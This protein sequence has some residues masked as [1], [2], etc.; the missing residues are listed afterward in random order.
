MPDSVLNACQMGNDGRDQ[1]LCIYGNTLLAPLTSLPAS[2]QRYHLTLDSSAT[3]NR[4][5]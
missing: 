4:R 1:A 3:G 5:L 2:E